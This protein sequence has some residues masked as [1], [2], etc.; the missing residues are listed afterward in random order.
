MNDTVFRRHRH[1]KQESWQHCYRPFGNA[2]VTRRDNTAAVRSGNAA[3]REGCAGK[4]HTSYMTTWRSVGVRRGN[5]AYCLAFSARTH[6]LYICTHMSWYRH[7]LR[8]TGCWDRGLS[9]EKA[10]GNVPVLRVHIIALRWYFLG[11][12]VLCFFFSVTACHVLLIICTC[13][14]PTFFCAYRINS[15]CSLLYL[16]VHTF[17]HCTVPCV[18]SRV[19]HHQLCLGTVIWLH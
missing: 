18:P 15:Y 11:N 19:S 5:V 9:C 6:Y 12:K 3:H 8:G 14:C 10:K 17:V 13:L 4:T 16:R 1:P 7:V 2:A